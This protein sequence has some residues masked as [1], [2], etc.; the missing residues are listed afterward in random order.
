VDFY[1]GI[2]Y[3]AFGIP[4]N[5]F[6]VMFASCNSQRKTTEFAFGPRLC[7]NPKS[8]N[9]SGKLPSIYYISRLENGFQWSVQAL[10]RPVM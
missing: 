5:M 8:E 6:T 3:R 7:E 1:N 9:P 10:T 4:V 2:I